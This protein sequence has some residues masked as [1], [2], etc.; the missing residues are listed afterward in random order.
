MG[1]FSFCSS[2]VLSHGSL[3]A[4]QAV[5]DEERVLKGRPTKGPGVGGG[6]GDA[7]MTSHVRNRRSR[8]HV[9]GSAILNQLVCRS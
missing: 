9:H 5:K 1:E 8:P 6:G 7:A 2:E 3:R 4:S